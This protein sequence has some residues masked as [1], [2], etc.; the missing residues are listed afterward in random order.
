MTNH[1]ARGVGFTAT[2][3]PLRHLN[4]DPPRG[5]G[6]GRA[7]GLIPHAVAAL[8]QRPEFRREMYA[9][10]F[11]VGIVDA[12]TALNGGRRVAAEITLLV[13]EF[14]SAHSALA[15]SYSEA[16]LAGYLHVVDGLL[17]ELRICYANVPD[18]HILAE[19][20]AQR[21]PSRA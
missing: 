14:E 10:G 20:L 7:D 1:E 19:Q 11:A 5:G 13:N 21:Q 16:R 2:L 18:H 9:Q 15:R 4:D 6:G 17:A 8:S 12:M 3:R